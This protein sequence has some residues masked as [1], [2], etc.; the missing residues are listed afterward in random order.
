MLGLSKIM[1]RT[2]PVNNRLLLNNSSSVKTLESFSVARVSEI[3]IISKNQKVSHAHSSDITD[4]NKLLLSTTS[5]G[6]CMKIPLHVLHFLLA[7]TSS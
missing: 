3:S 5:S 2:V 7:A 1:L 6:F 4:A